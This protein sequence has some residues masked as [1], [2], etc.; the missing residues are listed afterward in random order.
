MSDTFASF[1]GGYEPREAVG[2]IWGDGQIVVVILESK[3]EFESVVGSAL[4]FSEIGRVVADVVSISIPA[5]SFC[6]GFL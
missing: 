4:C 3:L 6:P 1:Y 2:R 5:V